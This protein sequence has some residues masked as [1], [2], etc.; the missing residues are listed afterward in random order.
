[1]VLDGSLQVLTALYGVT[2]I[3]TVVSY[4]TQIRAVW[5]SSTGA[6]DVSLFMWSLWSVGATIAVLYARFVTHDAGYLLMSLGNATGCFLVATLTAIKRAEA[7][8]VRLL[9]IGLQHASLPCAHSEGA[10]PAALARGLHRE[11]RE[12]GS[13]VPGGPRIPTDATISSVDVR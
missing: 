2:G 11:T 6:A 4:G 5:R 10:T 13:N 9:P 1:V 7:Q 12:S 3:V 8:G